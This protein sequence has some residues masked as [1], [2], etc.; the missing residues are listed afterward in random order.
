MRKELSA[1]FIASSVLIMAGFLFD[2]HPIA[3]AVLSVFCAALLVAQIPLEIVRNAFKRKNIKISRQ[4]EVNSQVAYENLG[5][6]TENQ[7]L[8]TLMKMK[9]PEQTRKLISEYKRLKF[10]YDQLYKVLEEIQPDKKKGLFDKQR[11]FNVKDKFAEEGE[12]KV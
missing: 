9:Q 6:R 3:F 8:K 10:Q 2:F 5:L 4:G 1:G 12:K 11:L 7:N